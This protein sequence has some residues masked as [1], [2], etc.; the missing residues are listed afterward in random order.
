[1]R[2]DH[3]HRMKAIGI[4]KRNIKSEWKKYN[5]QGQNSLKIA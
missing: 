5:K 3:F 1:M 4:L 2:K